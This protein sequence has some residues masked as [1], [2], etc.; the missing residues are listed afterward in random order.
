MNKIKL[1]YLATFNGFKTDDFIKYA[2]KN[3]NILLLITLSDG[4]KI[5]FLSEQGFQK[6]EKIKNN[7]NMAI[8]NVT[9]KEVQLKNKNDNDTWVAHKEQ[10]ERVYIGFRCNSLQNSNEIHFISEPNKNNLKNHYYNFINFKT[11]PSS[12]PYKSYFTLSQ[13]E[14]YQLCDY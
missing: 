2:D 12:D 5:A 3:N 8:F 1:L 6:G 7:K 11:S 13:I 14:L 10:Y 4:E 9:K